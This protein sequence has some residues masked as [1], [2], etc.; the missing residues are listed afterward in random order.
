MKAKM[1][2]AVLNA[3]F[4]LMNTALGAVSPMDAWITRYNG[5]ADEVNAP[6]LDENMLFAQEEELGLYE[7]EFSRDCYLA[8]YM[9][10]S[11]RPQ[12]I[13]L[14]TYAGDESAKGIFVSALASSMENVASES[15]AKAFDE[16]FGTFQKD[17]DG[18]YAYY[19]FENWVL[20]FSRGYEDGRYEMFSAFTEELYE[21]MLGEEE[22]SEADGA[23]DMP[24]EED[25]QPAVPESKQ[26]EPE[27]KIHKL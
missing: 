24:D 17:V 3:L 19:A 18:E 14:E 2:F 20:I 7:F 21:M 1:F 13:L 23:E 22:M 26:P 10:E 9:D 16:T 25:E 27:G 15:A 8:L 5:F 4:M 12:G 6:K 11:I